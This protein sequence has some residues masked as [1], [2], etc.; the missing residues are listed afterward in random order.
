MHS[1]YTDLVYKRVCR[2]WLDPIS[3]CNK[4]DGQKVWAHNRLHMSSGYKLDRL[5]INCGLCLE[6]SSGYPSA[7]AL[8]LTTNFIAHSLVKSAH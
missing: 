1:F 6:K 4:R 8:G 7:F 3:L 5:Y 2:L